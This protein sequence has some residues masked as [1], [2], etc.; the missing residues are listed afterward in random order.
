MKT[1]FTSFPDFMRSCKIETGQ[2]VN[3]TLTF[4]LDKEKNATVS[5]DGKQYYD[6]T[7]THEHYTGLTVKII[8]KSTGVIESLFFPFDDYLIALPNSNPHAKEG[9]F[10]IW[11]NINEI[12][13]YINA[14]TDDSMEVMTQEIR[15]Y[16]SRWE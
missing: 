5:L 6:K 9:K 10:H 8:S 1:D 4:K 7:G 11:H 15:D 14:P 3:K 16:C 12:R 2:I 13:W